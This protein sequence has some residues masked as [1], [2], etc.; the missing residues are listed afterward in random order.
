MDKALFK[1]IIAIVG[2]IV[3]VTNLALFSFRV[4]KTEIFMGVLVF[5]ALLS[6]TYFNTKD[7]Q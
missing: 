3:L 5:M 6:Y 4:I 1:K 2:T 7:K